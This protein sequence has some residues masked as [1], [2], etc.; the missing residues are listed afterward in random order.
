MNAPQ[1]ETSHSAKKRIETHPFEPQGNIGLY[2][3]IYDE[4]NKLK[5]NER[6]KQ[7]NCLTELINS[8]RQLNERSSNN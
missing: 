3:T 1:H 8:E 4:T 6:M 7:A 5:A 2:M